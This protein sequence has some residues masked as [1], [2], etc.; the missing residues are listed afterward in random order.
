[1]LAAYGVPMISDDGKFTST[2]IK[3]DDGGER[4]ICA[5]AFPA[6]WVEA[7]NRDGFMT[8][9]NYQSGDGLVFN[10]GPQKAKAIGDVSALAIV[11][12]STPSGGV[13]KVNRNDE[14][15]FV[16]FHIIPAPL[17]GPRHRQNACRYIYTR[18]VTP[19]TASLG[20]LRNADS[21]RGL[22]YQGRGELHISD[23]Q[24]QHGHSLGLRC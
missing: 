23:G 3:L 17:H 10:V 18:S 15:N 6:N 14:N 7:K 21:T 24:V 12:E 20:P 16:I 13:A 19:M 1:M 5:F 2:Y 4:T 8:A 11:A 22:C 9:A